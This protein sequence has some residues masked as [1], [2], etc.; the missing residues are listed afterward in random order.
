MDRNGPARDAIHEALQE[1]MPKGQDAIL[2]GW[3]VVAEW[4]GRDGIRYLSKA[5]SA[6]TTTWAANGMY[7][8]ALHGDWPDG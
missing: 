4:V 2:T 3:V 8:D 5:H 6:S 7:H 1:H